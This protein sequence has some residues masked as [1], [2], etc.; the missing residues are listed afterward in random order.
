MSRNPLDETRETREMEAPMK[1]AAV[2][3]W[4]SDLERSGQ[5]A[6][7]IATKVEALDEFCE[8]AGATPTD[9]VTRCL[10]DGSV[11]I[12]ERKKVEKLIEEFAGESI[13]KANA[14]RSFMIHNG[15]RMI[16]PKPPWL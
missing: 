3:K 4:I 10:C 8:F 6:D 11:I 1:D 9:L 13:A 7:E 15:I 14:V 12:K 16:S 5:T 2:A